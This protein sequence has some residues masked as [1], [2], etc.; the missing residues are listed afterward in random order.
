M[1]LEKNPE[2]VSSQRSGKVPS[3]GKLNSCFTQDICLFAC[4]HALDE[5]DFIDIAK[6]SKVNFILASRPR[7]EQ[8]SICKRFVNLYDVYPEVSQEN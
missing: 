8:N 1:V 6:H 7:I 5:H 4:F 3:L 2:L